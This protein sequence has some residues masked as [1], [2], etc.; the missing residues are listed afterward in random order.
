LV[1]LNWQAVYISSV[2]TTPYLVSNKEFIDL[3]RKGKKKDL[4]E[5]DV[6]NIYL[7]MYTIV[8]DSTNFSGR[9]AKVVYPSNRLSCID[10]LTDYSFNCLGNELKIHVPCN[11]LRTDYFQYTEG[12]I[13]TIHYPDSSTISI[14]CGY[15]A[16]LSI[17]DNKIKGLYYKKVIV[18]GY[19]VTYANVPGQ[20]LRLF[21]TAFELLDKD[22]K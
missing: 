5:G 19:N 6:L 11:Y 10:S 21:N 16:S 4:T 3:D 12:Q 14:L 22:I 20:K 9:L 17:Q 15:E 7:K 1:A 2:L 18:K 8:E 13:L